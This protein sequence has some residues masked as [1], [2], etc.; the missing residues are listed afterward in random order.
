MNFL[1]WVVQWS[2][3]HPVALALFIPIYLCCLPLLCLR[4]AFMLIV[5]NNVVLSESA[6]VRR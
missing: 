4:A 3:D 1:S 6:E 2:D 5:L